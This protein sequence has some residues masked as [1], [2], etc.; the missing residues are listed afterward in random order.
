MSH[1]FPVCSY[2]YTASHNC[3]FSIWS[4]IVVSADIMFQS[5]HSGGLHHVLDLHTASS[6]TEMRVNT[7]ACKSTTSTLVCYQSQTVAMI[8][9][10]AMYSVSDD[11]IH[12]SMTRPA[13]DLPTPTRRLSW[14]FTGVNGPRSEPATDATGQIN[15]NR[16]TEWDGG[17]ERGEGGIRGESASHYLRRGESACERG[18]AISTEVNANGKDNSGRAGGGGYHGAWRRRR[19]R[20][21]R[22]R[23]VAAS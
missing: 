2:K 20:W 7:L 13:L 8:R 4:I 3:S 18:A 23:R 5:T 9:S 6:I 15:S 11:T 12:A 17:R 14:S 1:L 10:A 22:S 16:L 19:R 21:R